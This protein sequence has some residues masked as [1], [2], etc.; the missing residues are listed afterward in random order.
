MMILRVISRRFSTK[1]SMPHCFDDK[2]TIDV[3]ICDSINLI[4]RWIHKN[5]KDCDLSGEPSDSNNTISNSTI[6]DWTHKKDHE[7]MLVV[8]FDMEWVYCQALGPKPG[9]S[10]TCLIQ[11]AYNNSVLLVQT[12]KSFPDILPPSLIQL[13][14]SRSILKVGCGIAKDYVKLNKDY[15]ITLT[16]AICDIGLASGRILTFARKQPNYGLKS[17]SRHFFGLVLGCC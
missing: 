5:F 17:L 4:D 7:N 15:N 10:K 3:S 2:K 11:L 6:V 8:G 12:K 13:L 14:N 1:I 16:G 9:V